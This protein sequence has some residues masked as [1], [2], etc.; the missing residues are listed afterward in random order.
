MPTISS[1]M[2]G[3]V[4]LNSARKTATEVKANG[5]HYTPSELARF[6]AESLVLRFQ[7]GGAQN[8]TIT[9]LDPAC[10]D[11]ELL[12]A[13][14]R[15]L[16][17]GVRTRVRVL[18]FDKDMD[19]VAEARDRIEFCGVT[20]VHIRCE[21]F[22]VG[23]SSDDEDQLA[24]GLNTGQ[25]PQI[26]AAERADLI[27]SN[28]PYVRTQVL[29]GRQAG[30][31]ARQFGLAGRVDLYHAFVIAMTQALKPGGLLGLLT[32]NRFLSTQAG[33]SLRAWLLGEFSLEMLIDLGDTKLFNAAVLPAI[34][35]ARRQKPP[36]TL[37]RCLFRRVYEV[38]SVHSPC[39]DY[40]SVLA[41][42][43]SDSSG[44]VDVAGKSYR[45]EVGV[46]R[47]ATDSSVPWILTSDA[48]D[49]WIGTIERQKGGVFG[50]FGDVKVGIKTTADKVFIRD[51][52]ESL[53]TEH[54]PESTLLHPLVTHHAAARWAPGKNACGRKR[55]LYPYLLENGHRQPV[56]LADYPN[57][58]RYL[59]SHRS[60]L[61]GRR[62]VVESGRAWFEIWVPQNPAVWRT[63]K[64]AFPDI[65]VGSLFFLCPSG[66]IVNG[67]CYWISA[68][69]SAPPY[70]LKAMLAV[71]NSS[72]ALR[73]YDVMFHNK[74][75]A[76]RRRFMSQY[77][78]RF[79]LPKP[80]RAAE[81]ADAVTHL[82]A[83]R[84]RNVGETVAG[85]EEK[86]DS[87]VWNSFGLVKE[88]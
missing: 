32:S 46:L 26:V 70:T 71:A 81:L 13:L 67:D 86:L 74:L 38:D 20:D 21:D 14:L 51:D 18:G 28:P 73:Y 49:E 4:Q 9:I 85:L 10:G 87:L 15:A 30:M 34:L 17:A 16:P 80:K 83:A 2:I 1:S 50:D 35:V 48:T 31:L 54:Q 6:L 12:L 66:W 84:E 68:N 82:L 45:I 37:Q 72:L 57:T 58:G 29:G 69:A 56:D 61:E 59:D 42:L 76:G 75:Y 39:E 47:T 41:A 88:F 3:V 36:A 7:D 25:S 55:V 64:L 23:M 5:V 22:L 24:L 40:R 27:I 65:S 33:A 44:T 78:S 77:V 8:Q 43:S 79:P 11:G 60:I 53:P 62:Y 63:P 52:W 19:A